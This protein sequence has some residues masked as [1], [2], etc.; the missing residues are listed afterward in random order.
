M[1][2]LWQEKKN[3]IN[4]WRNYAYM[5]LRT[6]RW[7]GCL[8]RFWCVLYSPMTKWVIDLFSL[9]IAFLK[10]PYISDHQNFAMES[11][12][13]VLAFNWHMDSVLTILGPTLHYSPFPPQ[14]DH[15]APGQGYHVETSRV[16][17]AV[18]YKG[19]LDNQWAPP[20]LDR[21][22]APIWCIP[23]VI[24]KAQCGNSA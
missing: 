18:A 20:T 6:I 24:I 15:I 17:C 23:T 19:T 1:G 3:T 9:E 14:F 2:I 5:S 16:N 7:E 22:Y 4:I 12:E 10:D 11:N 13:F 8:H 21:T